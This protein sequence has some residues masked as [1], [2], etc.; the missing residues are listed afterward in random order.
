MPRAGCRI[1]RQIAIALAVLL[2]STPL[3]ATDISLAWDHSVTTSVVGYKVY[4]GNG[5]RTYGTPISIPYQDTY[6]V[7]GLGAGTWYFAV[8]AFDDLGNESDF[9]NEVSQIIKDGTTILVAPT[10]TGEVK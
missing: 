2:I 6:T 1:T 7:T 4:F 3:R 9:S 10:I 8:T 5:S